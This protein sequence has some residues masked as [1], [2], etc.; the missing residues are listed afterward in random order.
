MCDCEFSL[1]S[2]LTAGQQRQL[3]HGR[4]QS[5]GP[6]LVF[7]AATASFRT[8][9]PLGLC[10]FVNKKCCWERLRYCI[11]GAAGWL[12]A[13]SQLHVMPQVLNRCSPI[14]RRRHKSEKSANRGSGNHRLLGL[15]P[16]SRLLKSD[17]RNWQGFRSDGGPTR[18]NPPTFLAARTREPLVV[19][20]ILHDRND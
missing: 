3:I 20:S 9:A 10:T 2:L 15:L 13:N 11:A 14:R 6:S 18:S 17:L 8:R 12:C 19:I 1:L 7:Q 16:I 4:I 5:K